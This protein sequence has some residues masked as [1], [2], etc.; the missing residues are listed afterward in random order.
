M[1]NDLKNKYYEDFPLLFTE[2][3]FDL[4]P[5][6]GWDNL[7]YTLC[8]RIQNY[9]DNHDNVPQVHV[10]Q[11]KEKFAGLI[12]YYDGGDD[13]IRGL[14]DLAQNLSFS[15]CEICGRP[16]NRCSPQ[17]RSWIKTR[18]L[19][20]K[21]YHWQGDLAKKRKGAVALDFDGV[22]NS[23]TSGFVSLT[24]IPDPP[25]E[26]SIE[27]IQKLV[28]YGF[29]VYIYSTRND[30]D[31]GRQAISDYLLKHGLPEGVL[32]KVGIKAGKP[33]AKI[34]LDDRAWEFTGTFPDP[35]EI[36]CF[37]PWHGGVSSTQKETKS[38]HKFECPS[39][40][41][42]L[43]PVMQDANSA[44]NADQF[45]AIRAGDYYCSYCPEDKGTAK[46]SKTGYA[47]FWKK[48]VQ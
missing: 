19:K 24:K 15:I 42:E 30:Q 43:K 31:K 41:K 10:H 46:T 36:E 27:Y 39:C 20:H 29:K 21:D 22:I 38:H 1:S 26:G 17:G 28:E 33:A 40:G 8:K 35:L 12:F 25:V 48:D 5:Q 3:C 34:Y 7:I 16:G 32:K 9:L 13:Y 6:P 4:S 18:C 37:K 2:K 23:Y 44:L 45:D 11:I 47:Y 14:V